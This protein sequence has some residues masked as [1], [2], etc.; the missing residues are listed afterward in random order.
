MSNMYSLLNYI[1][2]TSKEM[3]DTLNN[4]ATND[5]FSS[6]KQDHTMIHSDRAT[7][8]SIVTGSHGNTEEEKRLITISTI[9]VVSRLALE[10]KRDDVSI[11]VR[12]ANSSA[13]SAIQ[14]TKLTI[15]MLIQRLRISEP[16]AEAAIAHNLVDLALQ[17]PESSFLEI[18]KAFSSLSLSMQSEDP[19]FSNNMVTIS[20]LLS[21]L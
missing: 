12:A 13:Q 8:H 11:V 9:S 1:A 15:A 6:S 3:S 21:S 2:A 20:L 7:L 17:A 14:A 16:Y 4:S 10:F 5:L 18:I 19:R